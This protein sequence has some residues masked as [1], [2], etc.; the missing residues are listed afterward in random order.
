[1]ALNLVS[2]AVRAFRAFAAALFIVGAIGI[3]LST[4]GIYAMM[5]FTVSRRTREIAGRRARGQSPPSRRRD[6]L[7]S[8]RQIGAGA[9]AG[10]AMV[11][12]ARPRTAREIWLPLGL[13]LFMLIIGLFACAAPARRALRI[14]PSDAL[15]EL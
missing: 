8:R 2:R 12:A 11:I 4:A 7:A 6:L 13:A 15:K 1:M 10:V 3:L 5:S 14:E 9:L